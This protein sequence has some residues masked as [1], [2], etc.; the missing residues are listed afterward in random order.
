MS[1]LAI[2]KLNELF[3]FQHFIRGPGSDHVPASQRVAVGASA[4][5]EYTH[6]KLPS[7]GGDDEEQGFEPLESCCSASSNVLGIPPPRSDDIHALA[8][9]PKALDACPMRMSQEHHLLLHDLL[10][11]D[12]YED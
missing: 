11:G 1:K 9:P 10:S 5:P 3:D 7:G 2:E 6:R 8:G 4:A 12:I